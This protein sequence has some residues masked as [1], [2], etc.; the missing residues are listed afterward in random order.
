L[1]ASAT[2]TGNAG[3]STSAPPVVAPPP[4][5]QPLV[6]PAD[7]SETIVE[8]AAM[9][10]SLTIPQQPKV[11]DVSPLP[12][13]KPKGKTGLLIGAV[14][15]VL[16]VIGIAVGGVVIYK[17]MNPKTPV[18]VTN[19]NTTT[20]PAGPLEVSRYWLMLEPSN[21][22]QPPTRVAGLVP[23]A[24]GQK[25]QMRLQFVDDGYVYIVGP[26]GDSNKP[27]AFLTTKPAKETGLTNN[28]VTAN[29]EFSFPRGDGLL[30]LDTKPG[31]DTFTVIFSKT[32]LESPSFLSSQVTGEPMA[33][34]QLAE[35]NEFIN[36]YKPKSPP[37]MEED[38][39][40]NQ[41]R[42]VRVKV[43]ADPGNPIVF[44]VRIQHN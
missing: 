9:A 6:S 10:S 39:S 26:G 37:V 40:N 32:R 21:S 15:L 28:S 20:L 13:P 44:E 12:Q 29:S 42:F 35:F 30:Q 4:Y 7:K 27:T 17:V 25:F 36:K 34:G 3:S 24:S 43:T 14:V 2:S 31:T 11:V 5:P 23:I 41:A 33:A 1:D 18:V 22:N 38:N 8:A 16:V 19:T